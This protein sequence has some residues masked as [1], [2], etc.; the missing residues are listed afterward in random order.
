MADE[1]PAAEGAAPH[2][3]GVGIIGLSANGGWASLAHLPALRSM[4]AKFDVVALSASSG[5]SAEAAAKAHA[6][7]MATSDALVL[8]SSGD[9]ELVV[10]AVKVPEH[11]DLVQKALDCRKDVYCEWPLGRNTAEAEEMLDAARQSGVRHFVGLQARSSPALRYIRDLVEE[12]YVGRVI[13]TRVTGSGG[14]PWSGQALASLAYT[15]DDSLGA[16]LFT[17]PFGHMIDGFTWVLGEFAELDATMA[18]Q[19]PQVKLTDT[20]ETI[21][22]NGPDE[23]VV[24][25]TLQSGAVASLHYTGRESPAGNLR[26]EI[27]GDSGALL[28]ESGSGHLQY[29]HLD[30]SGGQGEEELRPLQIPPIYRQCTTAEDS[31]ADSVAH[32]YHAVSKDLRTGAASVPDFAHALKLHRLLD[33]IRHAAGWNMESGI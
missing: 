26:W 24:S 32:A 14:F 20:G 3:C 18:V 1:E 31:H 16:T 13:S 5:K 27:S 7:S 15:L 21:A 11:R 2:S 25:G 19:F 29:G 17:I 6:V 23:V 8:A 22:A 4:P 9:V 33:R 28:I 12:G 10:V 30:I